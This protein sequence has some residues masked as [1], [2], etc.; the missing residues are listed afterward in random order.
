MRLCPLLLSV[1]LILSAQEDPDRPVA[2]TPALPAAETAAKMK[3]PAG[4]RMEV[5]A[6]EPD[7]VQPIA[8]TIDDR[9]RLWVLENTNYPECPGETKDR[10]LI[11]EDTHG[12]GK[13][14]TKTTFFYKM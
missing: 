11:F 2:Q 10:I 12:A 3:L 5:I 9:G 6:Q 1:P 13:F 14:D 7:V 4:F 8:Y